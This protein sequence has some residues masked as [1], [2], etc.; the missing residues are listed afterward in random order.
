MRTRS[1]LIIA[2]LVLLLAGAAHA[3]DYPSRPV[4]MIVPFVPGGSSDFVARVLQPKM[5][6]LLGQTVVV[7][8]RAGASGNVGVEIS[9]RSAPDGYT[10]FLG[11]VGST[12]INPSIFPDFP[13]QTGARSDRVDAAGGRAGRVRGASVGA[14]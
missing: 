2:V 9:A 12:A 14:G 8:N 10:I 4:R 11:N 13:V 7:D 3:Q 6:E 1:Q 5:T